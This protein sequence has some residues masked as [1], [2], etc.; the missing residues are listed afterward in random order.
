M[1]KDIRPSEASYICTQPKNRSVE[2]V[3]FMTQY[4]FCEQ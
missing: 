3:P 1:P 2:L 4:F